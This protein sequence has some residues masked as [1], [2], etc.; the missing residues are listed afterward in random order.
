[1][2]RSF[3]A[4][5]CWVTGKWDKLDGFLKDVSIDDVGDFNVGIGSALLALHKQ[6]YDEFSK[7]LQKLWKDAARSLSATTASSL[8][9]CHDTMLRFHVLTEVERISGVNAST[10]GNRPNLITSLGLRLDSLGAYSSDKQYL[11]GLR[12]ATMEASK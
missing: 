1:M 3:A 8:Q 11:L 2:V 12:R 5:A 6:D 7:R 4:E 9:S 10:L